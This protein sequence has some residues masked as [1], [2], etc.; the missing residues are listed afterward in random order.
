MRR[1]P[2]V[3]V[4]AAF[5][6]LCALATTFLPAQAAT[7]RAV[8]FHA[9][10]AFPQVGTETT[11]SG[12]VSAS[13]QGSP[14]KIQELQSTTWTD[15]ADVSTDGGGSFSHSLVLSSAGTK[16]YRAVA[17]ATADADAATSA[18]VVLK[19]K[20]APSVTFDTAPR[21]TVTGSMTVGSALRAN[22][23][24][25][26][27][28]PSAFTYQWV[29]DGV[30]LP[31]Y[32]YTYVV[33]AEDLG[34]HLTVAVGA[35]RSGATTIR[36]SKPGPAVG[37]GT[38]ITQP[39]KIVGTAK[40][41]E[42]VRADISTW[43]PQPTTVTYQWLRNRTPIT[44]A[45]RVGYTL[46]PGDGGSSLSVEV[47][48]ESNGVDP[49]T[50]TSL[51]LPV[52]GSPPSSSVTFGDVMHP[53]A[54]SRATTLGATFEA[55]G[56]AP[57]WS[58]DRLVRW[59]AAGA[60]THSLTPHAAGTLSGANSATPSPNAATGAEY[61][62]GNSVYKNADVSFDF[63]GTRFAVEYRSYTAGDAQIW[64]DG[65]PLSGSPIEAINKGSGASRNWIV[66]TL[67]SRQTVRVR[68]A[69]PL[70]FTGVHTPTADAAVVQAGATPFTLGVVSDSFYE[71]CYAGRCQ[72]RSA[73]PTLASL[74]G[75]RI[76]NMAQAATG[77][78]NDGSGTYAAQTGDGHGYPGNHTSPYGSASRMAAL[79][80]APIDAVLV[81]GTL[82][83]QPVW[84]PAQHL[85][86][87]D[88]LIGKIET[89][90]PDL[91]IVLVGI[92]PLY[93]AHAFSSRVSYYGALTANFAGMVGR[94]P[95]VVGFIDP[96]TNHWFTGSGSTANPRGDGNQ[97]LYIGKDGIHP[98]GDG[99]AYY[100]GKIVDTLKDLPLPDFP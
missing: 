10:A 46:T 6:G 45:T 70:V 26:S 82:N 99:Q 43:S 78:I 2:L 24:T 85:A 81:N 47:R 25:W 63:T 30:P 18:T 33:T 75:F 51:E 88:T 65:H 97:D 41:G 15:L 40:S 21:P 56:E 95:H 92:E 98:N 64:I 91:P 42:T 50:S 31:R 11:L 9:S 58:P 29:R 62:V 36:E 69:G 1:L 14:V 7:A 80:D 68:F 28:A 12:T 39:P 16:S 4:L 100:Q 8:E 17:P 27:P 87:V 57:T 5:L 93:F 52:P 77:Y 72:S 89:V 83:D 61:A 71:V 73:A 79:R 74:T 20:A 38:F 90:R 66:V 76:W 49:A 22:T 86:A 35:A 84:T 19:V 55:R 44:G 54:S 13:P 3:G 94:H 67:P 23:G 96:Y 60:F 59:D 34:K 48:G 32:W 37:R 53:A